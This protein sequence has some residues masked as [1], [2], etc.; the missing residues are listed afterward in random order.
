MDNNGRT[1]AVITGMG[2]LSCLGKSVDEYWDGLTSGRSGIAELTLTDTSGYP[3][4][5]GGEVRDFDPTQYV[6][7]KEARRLARF[8]QFAVGAVTEAVADA[9][10]DL[11]A[12]D[13][14]RVGGPDRMRIRGAS[15]DGPAVPHP[16]RPAWD[17]Y[18]SLFHTDDVGEHGVCEH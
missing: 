3:C 4:K 11:S 8:S 6:G 15:R 16:G 9:G 12:E 13:S 2:V 14:D 7:R 5:I 18:E 10:L 1:R 17:A